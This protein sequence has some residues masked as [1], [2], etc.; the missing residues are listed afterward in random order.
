MS[1]SSKV[2]F[3]HTIFAHAEGNDR[4][5]YGFNKCYKCDQEWN[6]IE[7]TPIKNFCFESPEPYSHQF[8]KHNDNFY[9]LYEQ[10]L[11]IFKGTYL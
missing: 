4:Y 2:P 7:E 9:G 10:D 6:I 1:L 5:C 3:K 11:Y 8:V